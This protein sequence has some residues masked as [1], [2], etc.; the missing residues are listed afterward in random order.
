[1]CA[2]TD[3]LPELLDAITSGDY[4]RAWHL[5]RLCTNQGRQ[6]QLVDIENLALNRAGGLPRVL[7]QALYLAAALEYQCLGQLLLMRG[8]DAVAV[9]VAAAA[10]ARTEERAAVL[11]GLDSLA[12][13]IPRDQRQALLSLYEG[14]FPAL[15]AIE[16]AEQRLK[17]RLRS[18]PSA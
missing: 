16:A 15:A 5:L 13:Y 8:A 17:A 12:G 18:R 6:L 7:D 3:I 2:G 4:K 10:R 1:M 11:R 9:A 14:V